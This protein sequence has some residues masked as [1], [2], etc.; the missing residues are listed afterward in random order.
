VGLKI[1]AAGVG[2]WIEV[3]DD[4]ALAQGGAQGEIEFLAREGSTG[5][6]VGRSVADVEGGKSGRAE[7]G[8]DRQGEKQM[9]LHGESSGLN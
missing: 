3:E 1:A 2:R 4:R 8:R 5:G 9:L 7:C 6:K